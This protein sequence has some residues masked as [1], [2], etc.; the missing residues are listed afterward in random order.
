MQEK[1]TTHA[2]EEQNVC[3]VPAFITIANFYGSDCACPTAWEIRHSKKREED[4]HRDFVTL[5]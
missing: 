1:G 4:L 2:Q 5:V 3:T